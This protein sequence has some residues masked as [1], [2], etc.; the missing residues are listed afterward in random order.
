MDKTVTYLCQSTS[1]LVSCLLLLPWCSAIT[2]CWISSDNN[3]SQQQPTADYRQTNKL[4]S[5]T[6]QPTRV[7]TTIHWIYK[8]QVKYDNTIASYLLFCVHKQYFNLWLYYWHSL[9]PV[10]KRSIMQNDEMWNLKCQVKFPL[11][12][13]YE[14]LWNVMW[15]L[16]QSIK[17]LSYTMCQYFYDYLCHWLFTTYTT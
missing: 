12:T 17:L 16:P 14:L 7:K 5:D 3:N 1:L 10:H 15:N 11:Q 8:Q 6:S 9:L 13:S 2:S 4:L